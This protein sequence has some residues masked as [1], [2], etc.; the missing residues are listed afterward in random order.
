MTILEAISAGSAELKKA[1]IETSSLDASLLLAHVLNTSRTKL[2]FF[3]FDALLLQDFS[4]FKKLINRRKN[5]ECTAYIIGRKEFHGLDFEVNPFVLVPRPD[6]EIL[7]ETAINYIKKNHKNTDSGIRVLDLCTGSGAVAIA[8]KNEI[9]SLEV[10][11][12]DICPKALE[13]AKRN[14]SRLLPNNQIKFFCGDLFHALPPSLFSL[15]VSNPPYIPSNEIKKL[16]VEVQ[17]E[18]HLALDGGAG[19]LSVIKRIIE[20]AGNYLHKNGILLMEASPDQMN[21]IAEMLEKSGLHNISLY[22]DLNGLQRVIGACQTCRILRLK[23]E[24][25]FD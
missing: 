12:S 15:I 5:G 2:F 19:G 10:W 21:E 8:L 24:K 6:T 17:N 1:G 23:T 20:Q 11:A 22:N 14:A 9:P 25:F 7:V 18:P 4:L 16:Q 3:C 13:T